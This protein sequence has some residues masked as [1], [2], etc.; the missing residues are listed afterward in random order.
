MIILSFPF[1]VSRLTC[2]L[3]SFKFT[4]CE[5]LRRLRRGLERLAVK[6]DTQFFNRS[7]HKIDFAEN[8]SHTLL[9]NI[10]RPYASSTVE[11]TSFQKLLS[12]VHKTYQQV[13]VTYEICGGSRDH[14]Y[15]IISAIHRDSERRTVSLVDVLKQ[16]LKKL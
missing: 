6:A 12:G 2:L 14:N 9:P 1:L 15:P 7:N 16:F 10:F 3:Y 5:H 8:F 11:H 13:T 4:F